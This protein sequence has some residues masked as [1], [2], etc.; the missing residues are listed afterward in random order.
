MAKFII[1]DWAANV[2]SGFGEFTTFDDSNIVLDIHCTEIVKRNHP[3][4]DD[5]IDSFY[6]LV[7]VERGEYVIVQVEL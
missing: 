4:L 2:M 1:K 3:A 7:D 5:M 6:D